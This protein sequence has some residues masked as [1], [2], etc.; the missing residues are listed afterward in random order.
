MRIKTS[1]LLSIV[2]AAGATLSS[3][4]NAE[5][6]NERGQLFIATVLPGSSAKPFTGEAVSLA[7]FN[8]RSIDFIET[9]PV[10]SVGPR[11]PEIVRVPSGFNERGH[12]IFDISGTDADGTPYLVKV[13]LF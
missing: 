3:G 12:S 8:E 5:S 11:G 7:G 1:A 13:D 9:A 2:L 10:G 6:Y 4:A